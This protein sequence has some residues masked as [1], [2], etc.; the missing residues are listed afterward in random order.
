MQNWALLEG[1]RRQICISQLLELC[2][3]KQWKSTS[4]L[5]IIWTR[6]MCHWVLTVRAA[7]TKM[8]PLLL[9]DVVLTVDIFPLHSPGYQLSMLPKTLQTWI[10]H[11]KL[12][13]YLTKNINW[14]QPSVLA[15]PRKSLYKRLVSLGAIEYSQ[16]TNNE[17]CSI[18]KGYITLMDVVIP[19]NIGLS[20]KAFICFYS[21]SHWSSSVKIWG[22]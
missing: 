1:C 7:S 18:P 10:F 6:K 15:R 13:W 4:F 21:G 3:N 11:P 8:L 9:S 17:S 14:L 22:Y 12:F 16:I 2:I 20:P 19:S 5:L